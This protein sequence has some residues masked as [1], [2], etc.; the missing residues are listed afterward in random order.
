QFYARWWPDAAWEDLYSATLFTV[1]LF[2]WDDTIDTNEHFLASDF[3]KA[4]IWRKQSLEYFEYHLG[5]LEEE[6]E[7]E[8]P[9]DACLLFKEFGKRFCSKFGQA[10]RQRMFSRIQD[11]VQYNM[12]EQAERLA[13]RIPNYEQY[14]QIRFGVTGV[15][16]F[17]LLLE[18]T[19]RTALPAEIM[20]SLEMEAIVRE[21]NFIIIVVNDILSLKKEIAT[22]CVVNI[23][24][25]LLKTGQPL[26]RVISGLIEEMHNS[27]DRLDSMAARL[28]DMT[29]GNSQLHK[30]VMRF[31]DGIRIMDTGTLI[32]S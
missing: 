23:V 20:D 9:D 26:D 21:C 8:S 10:Q 12:V 7:P 32:Y 11:F 28:S 25:V 4:N 14:M 24:P 29:R 13:G 19:N 22:D 17:S 18:I 3:D 31:I 5:L 30:D 6:D 2:I 1:C 16:M 27:R 15:R